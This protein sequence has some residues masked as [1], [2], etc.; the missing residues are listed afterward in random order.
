MLARN[1]GI[2]SAVKD[3][4]GCAERRIQTIAPEIVAVAHRTGR[5]RS[6]TDDL[7]RQALSARHE[8]ALAG[9]PLV[10][11]VNVT[12]ADIADPLLVS[13]VEVEL[14]R[15]ATP[16]EALVLEV[17]ESD[18]MKDPE[19]SLEVLTA[20]SA[21]GVTLSV[22]DF[23]TGYSSLAY[24]TDLPATELKLDRA[25]TLRVTTEPRTAAIVEGTVALAHR[26]GLRVIAEGVEDP[27]T[28]DVLRGLG[29]DETQGYL[30]ARPLDPG[31]LHAW[32]RGRAPEPEP[33][34]A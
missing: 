11:S 22:D 30:H 16:A 2:P 26:L 25:F 3:S 8:W 21:L 6:L 27:Q 9:H 15:S 32:L 33:V 12:P 23:G 29:V 5:V 28:L 24:L 31:A 19:R 14:A 13:R 4:S 10:V 18:A 17:T 20:L 34:P 1:V 7:I